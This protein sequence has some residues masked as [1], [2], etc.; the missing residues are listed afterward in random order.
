M[1]DVFWVNLPACIA[2]GVHQI[3]KIEGAVSYNVEDYGIALAR[4][5]G[6]GLSPEEFERDIAHS[7]ELPAYVWNSNE[8][9]CMKLGLSI[10][11]TR[12]KAVPVLANH[13]VRSE[14]LGETV[15]KGSAIGM[16][17]VVT[18]RTHQG[19]VIETQC[20]GKVYE[21]GEGD[22]CEFTVHGEP[23]TRFSV[24]KP[25]TVAHTCATIVNRIPDVLAA[26]AG[27]ITM[28]KLPYARY[29]PYPMFVNLDCL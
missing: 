6:V 24:Q 1:Q 12:Q 8:A 10:E 11:E 5:H 18:T 14:T 2:G 7:V 29:L 16:S 9:L 20:I 23:D 4:A 28:D 19:I 27:F 22:L 13:D 26:P 17:A 3:Q 21:P 25:D 15:K